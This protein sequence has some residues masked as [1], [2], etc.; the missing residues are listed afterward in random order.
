MTPVVAAIAAL[1]GFVPVAA[2]QDGFDPRSLD[3][4]FGAT[5][6]DPALVEGQPRVSLTRAYIPDAVDLSPLMPPPVEQKRGSC[7]S[8]AV[9][10]AARGYYS[11]LEQ[12]TTPGDDRHTPSP[13]FLHTKLISLQSQLVGGDQQCEKS[14]SNAALALIYLKN[15]GAPTKADVPIDAICTAGA[16]SSDLPKNA[17]SI[18]NWGVAFLATK[19]APHATRRDLDAIKQALAQGNPVM[20]AFKLYAQFPP[21]DTETSTL[22]YLRVDEVY[23]GSL[24]QNFGKLEGGHEMTLVGY[25]EGRQAF[26]VQNSW[27]V[28]WG[29]G[30]FGWIGYDA[31]MADMSDATVM[32]TSVTPPVPAPSRPKRRQPNIAKGGC[33]QVGPDSDP[34]L[35][36]VLTGFV[37]TADELAALRKEFGP[38][39]TA[40]VSVRPWPVCE[41]LLTLNEPLHAASRPQIAMLGGT[42]RVAFGGNLGFTVTTPNFPSFLYVVY[43]QADGTV[44]NLV[45]RRGP[46]REQLAP[47]TVLRFGDGAEG[48]QRFR[49]SPPAGTEAVIAIAARSPMQ[50]LEDLESGG[51]AQFRLVASEAGAAAAEPANDRLYLSQLRTAMAEKIKTDV[52]ER[53]VTA[54]IMHLTVSE[55]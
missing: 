41:A 50:Q 23:H 37:G 15:F 7:V 14:G 30:G 29:D 18:K 4:L 2:A 24:A 28:L 44:V 38:E 54:G 52:L 12:G 9:G 19:Q 13:A 16:S 10:Y 46:I 21:P 6:I 35:D 34:K 45:P 26:R 40:S 8:H 3:G 42:D 47:G 5:P 39:R 25:D 1:L 32:L 33:S 43:L 51:N 20:V 53:E 17:F 48:R 55:R 22:Q 11:A 31:A 36:H 49:A 27:G